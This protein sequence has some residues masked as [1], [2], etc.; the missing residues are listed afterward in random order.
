[1]QRA[2]VDLADSNTDNNDAS[3]LT[4]LFLLDLR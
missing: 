4:E 2:R 3:L 1:L